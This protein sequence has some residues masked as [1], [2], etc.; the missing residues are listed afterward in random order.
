MEVPSH[1]NTRSGMKVLP[2]ATSP[3]VGSLTQ[4]PLLFIKQFCGR[5]HIHVTVMISSFTCQHSDP[6][7]QLPAVFCAYVCASSLFGGGGSF[8]GIFKKKFRHTTLSEKYVSL[9][10]RKE[11]YNHKRKDLGAVHEGNGAHCPPSPLGTY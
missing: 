1:G 8:A 5:L 11:S 2:P 7:I 4:L 3:A 10:I 9:I 6:S